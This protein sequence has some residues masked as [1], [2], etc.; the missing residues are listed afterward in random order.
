MLTRP[1]HWGRGRRGNVSPWLARLQPLLLIINFQISKFIMAKLS[2]HRAL[3][4]LKLIDSKISRKVKELNPVGYKQGEGLVN[5]IID[6]NKF[7]KDAKADY[8]S[9][10]SL[11]SRKEVIKSA[12][13]LA[14]CVTKV[15]IG[16]KEYTIT[17]AI[18]QRNSIIAKKD[19]VSTMKSKYNSVVASINRTNEASEERL[20]KLLEAMYGKESKPDSK[21]IE[22][23]CTSYRKTNS[24]DFVDPLGV[25]DQFE[26]LE[27]EIALFEADV[28][29]TLSEINS[30]TMIEIA[31]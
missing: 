2:L 14:N 30:L 9:L 15:T 4:E 25:K 10:M 1:F 21:A 27:E 6:G 19:V 3:A 23:T 16:G 17:D 13:M 26:K 28:D 18:T 12:I 8:D 31:D 22:A 24:L 7:A 20:Q 11:I 29:A 5:G